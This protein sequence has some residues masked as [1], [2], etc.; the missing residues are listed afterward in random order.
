LLFLLPFA[1]LSRKLILLKDL[2]VS[3]DSIKGIKQ[4]YFMFI[5]SANLFF[6]F[7]GIEYFLDFYDYDNLSLTSIS[8]LISNKV[9]LNFEFSS[10]FIFLNTIIDISFTKNIILFILMIFFYF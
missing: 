8:L 9:N 7:L 1:K 10:V 3:F 5:D 6:N 2:K 4:L